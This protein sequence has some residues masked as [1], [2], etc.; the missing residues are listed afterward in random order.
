MADTPIVV[1]PSPAAEQISAGIRTLIV[2]VG[3]ISAIIGLLGKHD[4]L[5]LVVYLQSSA[6]VPVVGA[7]GAVGAF[8]YGQWKTIV[9][10]REA[11]TIAAAA[12]DSVAVI[13]EPTS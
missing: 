9:R 7:A 8:L 10:K 6:A 4:I 11:V 2:L 12:P 1:N 3:G 13:K 5:G